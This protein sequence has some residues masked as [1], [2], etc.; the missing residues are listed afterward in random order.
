MGQR[1]GAAR[2]LVKTAL[3]DWIKTWNEQDRPFKRTKTAGQI[4]RPHLPATATGSQDR[5]T[6]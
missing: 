2:P 6:S 1:Q 5:D 3:E 4:Y